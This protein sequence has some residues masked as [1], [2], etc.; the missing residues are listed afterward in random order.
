MIIALPPNRQTL[1]AASGVARSIRMRALQGARRG[2][3]PRRAPERQEPITG[4]R[5]RPVRRLRQRLGRALGLWRRSVRARLAD[6]R[7]HQGAGQRRCTIASARAPRVRHL[8]HGGRHHEPDDLRR[9]ERRRDDRSGAGG[10]PCRR[11]RSAGLQ[12]RRQRPLRDQPG[13]NPEGDRGHGCQAA[14]TREKGST[15]PSE[16]WVVQTTL[17]AGFAAVAN[18]IAALGGDPDTF[19]RVAGS[20]AFFG[21]PPLTR[22]E[23]L[24]SSSANIIDP[25]STPPKIETGTLSGRARIGHD[26]YY[27]LRCPQVQ[28]LRA[29]RSTTSSSARRRPGHAR[30]ARQ[31]TSLPTRRRCVHHRQPGQPERLSP[32]CGRRTSPTPEITYSDSRG[33]LRAIAY[34]GDNRDL[35]PGSGQGHRPEPGYTRTQFCNLVTELLREF[36]WLDNTSALVDHYKE[37]LGIAAGRGD[38]TCHHRRE[39]QELLP[40]GRRT[41]VAPILDLLEAVAEAASRP[42]GPEGVRSRSRLPRR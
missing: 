32:T 40:P 37:A 25:T 8:R 3:A 6:A 29:P 12:R 1:D 19:Y 20:Y 22:G 14:R 21:G 33:D 30:P 42:S 5:R 41:I 24:Q 7:R 27:V 13:P 17:N 2:P 16:T 26:G 18:A 11:D 31:R 4:D 23:V 10:L 39:P 35:R 36:E 38:S 9:P 15:P 34:P 28:T